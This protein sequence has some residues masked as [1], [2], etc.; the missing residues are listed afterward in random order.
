M[1]KLVNLPSASQL[2]LDHSAKPDGSRL[3]VAFDFDGTLTTR[4]TLLAF[5]RYSRGTGA[6]LRAL[7]CYAPLLVLMKLHLY[8]NDK[9]KQ[10]VF[11]HFFRGM[12]LTDFDALCQ[13]FAADNRHLLR[14]KGLDTV[15]QAKANGAE[16]LIV[17]ASIDN[18]VQ[19]FF[20]SVKV[21]GTQVEV[22]DG[23]LTGRF[24]TANCY[25]QEK[26][27]RILTLYPDRETYH[28]TAYG[29]SRGDRE[30]LAFA[31]ESYFR[32]FRSR[33]DLW[34]L[35][36]GLLI[37]LLLV[38]LN[39]MMFMKYDGLFNVLGAD[40]GSVLSN[41]FHVSGFDPITYKVLTEWGMDY[42]VLRHPL[43]PYLM[44]LPYWL[45]QGLISLTGINGAMYVA[46]AIILGCG[47]LSAIFLYRM[48][49]ELLGLGRCDASLLTLLFFSF[50]YV[51]VTYFV[52]DH[53]GISLMLILFSLYTVGNAWQEGRLL[54]WWQT[55]LLFIITSGVTLTNGAKVYAAEWIVRGRRFFQW[56]YF[57]LAVVLPSLLMVGAGMLEERIYVYPKQQA[58]RQY[59]KAHKAEMIA[60][61]RKNHE[62][63]KNAPWVIHKGTPLGKGSLLKWTDI[64]TP[65]C[66]TLIENVFGEPIQLHS[67]WVLE[68]ILISYRPVLLEYRSWV[69]YAVEGLIVLLFLA[70][71]ACGWRNCLLWMV[72]L[73]IVP[74]ALMHLGFGFAINEVSIMATHWIYV[75]PIALGCLMLRLQGH[76]LWG[77]RLLLLALT[78]YLF[79]HNVG[80]I[81]SWMQQAPVYTG[82][83]YE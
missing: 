81:A 8:P 21:L 75:I 69:N 15:R 5:I 39:G 55:A 58:E 43:L 68:D 47:F 80:L 44:Y 31:D 76:W 20:P 57:L 2:T 18:W 38:A 33:H 24:L 82:F 3:I 25:G 14:S 65:R 53:F 73:G 37:L 27:N 45:N 26:V 71:I 4:D 29:D 74:D 63:Y 11:S 28:L 67:E 83:W 10:K 46:A 7:L 13:R 72:L 62:R 52:P 54:R 59:F 23:Q 51:L 6:L 9:A 34:E 41:Y 16:V 12:R 66:E 40:Y 1:R 30:L 49:Y 70:G 79:V 64:T 48:L 35:G 50:G 56:R 17:S 22:E 60:K 32:P 19:P 61:A 78:A 77:L 36:L 42:D